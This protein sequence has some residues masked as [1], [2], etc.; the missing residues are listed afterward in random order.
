MLSLLQL[1]HVEHATYSRNVEVRKEGLC[2]G[3]KVTEGSDVEK[4]R[5]DWLLTSSERQ[6]VRLWGKD[7][8][9]KPYED[10]RDVCRECSFCSTLSVALFYYVYCTLL[11]VTFVFIRQ[12]Y[13]W[14]RKLR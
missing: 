10:M 12:R 1:Q 6:R 2:F 3:R 4:R 13:R 9:I 8:R 14:N 11:D 5:R 7:N